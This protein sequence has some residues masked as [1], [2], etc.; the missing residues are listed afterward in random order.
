MIRKGI[1]AILLTSIM[2]T[3]GCGLMVVGD[4]SLTNYTGTWEQEFD[5]TEGEITIEGSNGTITVNVWDQPRVEVSAKW[6]AKAD[7]YDFQ[8]II[9]HDENSLSIASDRSDRTLSGTRYVISVPKGTSLNLRSSNGGINVSGEALD[10]LDI[11]TS[12]GRALVDNAGTGE[13]VVNTSNG[14]ARVNGW[15]GNVY[16]NTSNGAI[17]AIMD[18]LETGE[19]TFITSNGGISVSVDPDSSFSVQAS[20]S[21]GSIRNSLSGNWSQQPSGSSHTGSYNGGGAS[22]TIRTSN[23][24]VQ[25]LPA[26]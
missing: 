24:N 9:N 23:S 8:P 16:C 25:M 2:I 6:S 5:F 17:T 26:N 12:N 4:W 7:N 13:L 21:N 11:R 18:R 1:I 10:N 14:L 20:T 19:Y 3:S 15:T 22:M